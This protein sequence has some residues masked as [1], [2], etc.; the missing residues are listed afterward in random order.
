MKMSRKKKETPENLRSLLE[1]RNRFLRVMKKIGISDHRPHD[2]RKDF[3]TRA[4]KAGCDE[5]A[6][7]RIVGHS[8]SDLTERVYTE[9]DLDWLKKEIKKIV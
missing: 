2:G 7:K 4:K 6:I 9:R 8:I 5:Y 1:N 3:I